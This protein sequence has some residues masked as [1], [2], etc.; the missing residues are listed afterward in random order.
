[1][2]PRGSFTFEPAP[3]EARAKREAKPNPEVRQSWEWRR[4][5]QADPESEGHT[6][7]PPSRLGGEYMADLSDCLLYTS[8]SPRDSTSS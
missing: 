5:Q 6:Q 1:M 8:P 4:R 2:L 7:F 3:S